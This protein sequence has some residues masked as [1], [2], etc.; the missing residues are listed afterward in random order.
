MKKPFQIVEISDSTP[1]MA[2]GGTSMGQDKGEG[3][4]ETRNGERKQNQ[5]SYAERLKTNVKYDQR[6]K[7]NILE[8]EIE[9]LDKE[10]EI[11]LNQ[12]CVA[13][14]LRS[15]GMN[16]QTQLR[17]YQ[18]IYGRVVT[19]SVWCTPGVNLEMFCRTETI[20]V[21]RGVWTKNIR[22][23]GRRDVVVTVIGLDFNTPDTLVQ[24]Y[25]EKFGGKMVSHEVIYGKY[26]DGPMRGMFNGERRYNVEFKDGARPMGTFHFLDGAK[27]RIFYRGNSKTCARCHKVSGVCPGGG[28]AKECH[29]QDGQKVDLADHMRVLWQEIDFNPTTFE[30]PAQADPEADQNEVV[31][32]IGISEDTTFRRSI[33][34]PQMTDED[35][36][37][38]VGIQIKNLPPTMSNAEVAAF[39]QEKVDKDI[40][41]ERVSIMKNEHS[42]NASIENGLEGA[43]VINA[44]KEIEFR[45]SKKK[46]FG[47]P[48]Y[49]RILK[50]LTPEKTDPIPP[51]PA[52]DESQ[53]NSLAK[54]LDLAA[55]DQPA[56]VK[57]N[58]T[59]V[60][61]KDLKNAIEEKVDDKKPKQRKLVEFGLTNTTAQQ[62]KRNHNEVSS[63]TS[64][65]VKKSPKKSKAGDKNKKL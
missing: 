56:P 29:N 24:G 42:I 16:I 35:I 13:R 59:Q 40:T 58:K 22:P 14:L 28:Y 53:V 62:P 52:L 64:P 31:G 63:P 10:N 23:A 54:N 18:V 27:V 1:A 3:N 7:R 26:G 8:I 61:V 39:L 47:K 20:Q 38:V 11:I 4:D 2:E 60:K 46:F 44:A 48:L 65:E 12:D 30:L 49:C 37:K 57:N 41:I 17:G 19:L 36:K 34:R 50:N 43:T 33:E 51:P 15:I 21:T 9:K 5:M 55:L 6:L 25:I 45:Q 32:D